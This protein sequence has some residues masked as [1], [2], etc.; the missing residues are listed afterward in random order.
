ME[1]TLLFL[2]FAPHLLVERTRI[3]RLLPR[4][5]FIVFSKKYGKPTCYSLYGRPTCYFQHSE[6]TEVTV[7]PE[8]E[9]CS[10]NFPTTHSFSLPP[11][12]FVSSSPSILVLVQL[13]INFVSVRNSLFLH[14]H[15]KTCSFSPLSRP[16][17]PFWSSLFA[18][19]THSAYACFP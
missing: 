1:T 16:C 8:L 7:S 13:I 5:A 14:P 17:L 3:T 18:P 10:S 12:L 4:E 9:A 11:T 19:S 15:R 6:Q 2:S